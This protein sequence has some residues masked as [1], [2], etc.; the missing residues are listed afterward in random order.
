MTTIRIPR[1]NQSATDAV[2][3]EWKA[4]PGDEV[5]AGQVIAL[6]ETDK[7]EIEIESP[8]AGVFQPEAKPGETYEV[9]AVIAT[10]GDN[11]NAAKEKVLASPKAR[12][13]AKERGIDLAKIKGTG[14]D[15]LVVAGDLQVAGDTAWQGRRVRE[16]R[17]LERERQRVAQATTEAWRTPHFVQFVDVDLTRL[18]ARRPQWKHVTWTTL[19]VAALARALATTPELNAAV[20]GDDLVLFDGVNIGVAVETDRGLLVPVIADADTRPLKNLAAAVKRA[21]ETH[22]GDP[23]GAS[24][25]VSNLGAYGIRA[26][27]PVLNSPEPVLLF[28]GAVEDRAIVVDGDI[29]IRTMVTL[30]FAFDHRVT[31]G[32]PAARLAASVRN[33]LE[34]PEK[35]L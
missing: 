29:D 15:G 19:F 16:R 20:D 32:A 18:A 10:V 21:N 4:E 26:G 27:T 25:T 1:I 2:L 11:R 28:A 30:S 35:H 33:I 7:S 17:S 34:N 14:K 6:I 31:D 8:A 3:I 9:G 23:V 5:A 13:L 22:S 12:A 24:A